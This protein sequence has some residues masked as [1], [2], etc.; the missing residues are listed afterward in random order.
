MKDRV[1]PVVFMVLRKQNSNEVRE[2]KLPS[3]KNIYVFHTG[4]LKI[5]QRK[6]RMRK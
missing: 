6:L 2:W 5:E 3:V 4:I 1:R